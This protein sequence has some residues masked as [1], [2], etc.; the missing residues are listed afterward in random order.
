MRWQ[1]GKEQQSLLQEL[2]EVPCE[3]GKREEKASKPKGMAGTQQD[4]LGKLERLSKIN[5]AKLRMCLVHTSEAEIN[6]YLKS[7][8]ETI[9]QKLIRHKQNKIRVCC[10]ITVWGK[11]RDAIMSFCKG[12]QVL[13]LLLHPVSGTT[14]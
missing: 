5:M 6:V 1:Q 9:K 14:L 2:C 4:K 7:C 12:R 11:A 13:A 3:Q 10:A 8:E